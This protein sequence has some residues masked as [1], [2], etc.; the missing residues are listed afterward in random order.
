MFVRWFTELWLNSLPGLILKWQ[1]SFVVITHSNYVGQIILKRPFSQPQ[2]SDAFFQ[3]SVRV[4]EHSEGYYQR[5][6]VFIISNC[7]VAHLI[8][9]WYDD[10]NNKY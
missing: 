1:N 4:Q 7:M 6:E 2:F 10:Q 3:C 5:M 9:T 8:S